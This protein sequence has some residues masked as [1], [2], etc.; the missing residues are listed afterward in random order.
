MKRK[1][2]NKRQGAGFGV[3]ESLKRE[4]FKLD[5]W[6]CE[7]D[8]DLIP[9]IH[10]TD[11]PPPTLDPLE[12]S[13]LWLLTCDKTHRPCHKPIDT[14]PTRVIFIGDHDKE[15][16]QLRELDA[17]VEYI[18]LS[19]CWGQETP[20]RQK[21]LTTNSNYNQRKDAFRYNELP[22]VFQDA[23][24]GNTNDWNTEGKK[25]EDIFALAYCTIAASSASNW[26]TSFLGRLPNNIP[27]HAVSPGSHPEHD[28]F[29]DVD[30]SN[31]NTRAWVLQERILSRRTLFFTSRG[32]YWECGE[33]V[34]CNNL[35][36]LN[37]PISRSYFMDPNF[38]KRLYTSGVTRTIQFIQELIE[39]YTKRGLTIPTDRAVAFSGLAERISKALATKQKYGVFEI[40][41]HRLLLWKIPGSNGEPIAYENN[42]PQSWSWMAW[43]GRVEFITTSPLRVP[44]YLRFSKDYLN[45]EVRTFENCEK[46]QVTGH[47]T[48]IAGQAEV[49]SLFFDTNKTPLRYCVVI[50]MDFN[51]AREDPYKQYYVLVV[52]ETGEIGYYQ[53][54]GVGVIE[55]HCISKEKRDGKLV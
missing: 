34:R 37:C 32:V 48:I 30:E 13:R 1:R 44:K 47:Y 35:T 27:T 40:I 42:K 31:L 11:L 25:M 22:S 52:D 10:S 54:M 12:I 4:E 14:W 51:D 8:T 9:D 50:G 43:H 21:Y 33:G 24:T 41:M 53:R 19:H 20:E 5:E 15:K 2:T 29:Q 38:P 26:E 45:V 36:K 17:P 49:G 28:F 3:L 18:A 16:L 55:A 6:A 39:D 46:R 7:R 23:I